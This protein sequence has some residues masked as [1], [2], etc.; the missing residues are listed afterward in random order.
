MSLHT[1][2]NDMAQF[3]FIAS[4]LA[5]GDL[6]STEFDTS[7]IEVSRI[8]SLD[9]PLFEIAYEQL[10][11]QFGAA[12]EVE[13][14]EVLGRRM[15]WDAAVPRSGLAM[16]YDLL[17]VQCRGQFV[18]VRDHTAIA[19][20]TGVDV[21]LS[22]LL[23]DP[24]WRRG[25]LAG[26]LRALPIQTARGCLERA[27]FDPT[28]PITIAAEMEYPDG[29]DEARNIRLKAYGRAGFK[30]VD[31]AVVRYHQPDFRA[32][33]E[34]DATG[35]PVP[36]PFQLIIRRVGREE[37]AVVT[38]IEVRTLVERFYHMYG[39][40]FRESDMAVVWRQLDGYPAAE[41]RVALIPPTQEAAA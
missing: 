31:P 34:I 16:R 18:A 3:S 17:L 15:S 26:W 39:Q 8:T 38:G 32:P 19:D 36:L 20:A 13:S 27:G 22:H 23:I 33:E 5:P 10:W 37:Q 21:H 12:N 14:R 25:G 2:A 40:E 35:G 30:K 28:A 1:H 11:A 41:E 9:D 4:D 29:V 6:R 7:N 24:S